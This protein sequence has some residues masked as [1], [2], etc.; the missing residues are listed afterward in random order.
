ME[1][2]DKDIVI[3]GYARSAI[4]DFLGGLKDVSLVDLSTTVASAAMERSGVKPED[5]DELAMGCIYKHGN[6]GNPGRQVE[7]KCG[8]PS[9][10]WA[11]TVDQQCASGM[12]AL[13]IVSRSLMTDGCQLAVVVG[14]DV[15]SRV[16]YLSLNGRTGFR[17]GDV[18][19]V[20]GLTKEGLSCAIAGYHMGMTA[21]NL[22]VKYN[23][24]R[25]EQDELALMSNQRAIAAIDSGRCQKDIVPIEVKSRKS[26]KIV[27]TDEHP[28]RDVSLEGLAKLRPAFKPD[29]GTVTAGNASGINDGACA[30][31]VTTARYAKE[32]GL[33]PI[34]RVL[35]ITSKGVPA[36]I[37]GIGPAYAIPK[38]LKGVSMDFNDVDC[39]EINEAFAAQFL[40]VGRKLQ[41]EHGWKVDLEKT[42]VNGSGISLGHPIGCTGL[43]IIVT[44]LYE[45]ERRGLTVGGASLCVGGGPSMASL[46]TKDI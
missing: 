7:I 5:V 39:W 13:D 30:M 11:Y 27:D 14:A 1:L 21:E 25:E 4:G 33:K 8:I 26:V 44:M 6:G 28:R 23:I 22:A 18:K 42:N 45:M 10:A 9:E 12:K 34:A 46:W 15:M 19:L 20:D 29:G 31:V 36:E 38:C 3:L 43:R 2:K 17:M 16:P 37:M 24:S 32:H 41:E 40:G 35:S